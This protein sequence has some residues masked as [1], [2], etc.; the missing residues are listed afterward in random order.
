MTFLSPVFAVAYGAVLL[1]EPITARM[2]VC[3]AVIVLG[4]ALAT[5]LLRAPRRAAGAL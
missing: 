2:L 4:T 5:G 3:G 1:A